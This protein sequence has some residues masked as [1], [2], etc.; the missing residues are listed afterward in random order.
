MRRRRFIETVAGVGVGALAASRAAY[1]ADAEVQLTLQDSTP[2]ISPH[3]YGHFIEHLGGVID[4]GVWVGRDSRVPNIEGIRKQFLDDMKRIATPNL[5]W[6]GG[7]FADAYH[8]RDGIGPLAHRP[9]R[10][11]FWQSRMPEGSYATEPNGF[12]TH[13]FMRLC[14]LLGAEPYLAANVGSGTPREFHD[15]VSY[16]N[17]PPATESLADERAANGERDPFRVRYWGVGNES[18]GCGGDMTPVEYAT[19]YR[20][21]VTQ[22][23]VYVKPFLVATGPRGH[24]RDRDLAWTTGFFEAMKGH[25]SPVD[26]FSLHFYSDF[27]NTKMKVGTFGAPE[28]YAVL[29]EGL[30][31]ESVLLEHWAAM[32]KLDPE[33]RTRLLVDEWGVWYPPGEEITPRYILSQPLTLR[34]ALHTALTFDVFNRHAD[35][36]EMANVAQTVNCLHSLFLAHEDKYTRTPVY[37]VF[38]MYRGHMGARLVPMQIRAG[39]LAVAVPEGSARIAGLLG[40]ASIRGQRVLVTLTNPSLDAPITARIRLTGGSHVTEAR[41]TVLTHRDMHAANTFENPHAVAPSSLPVTIGG[42][43]ATVTLPRQAIAAVELQIV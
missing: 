22:F 43:A 30:R 26:G 12:G 11:N 17:A 36:V 32:G 1:A 10:Y 37:S 13:E 27:R 34:D 19:L 31:T 35:K 5:R 39:D 38:E 7:C 15:W 4:D 3:L 20:Q 18:W 16:C 33:H 8:W 9:R 41:G 28:W 42:D 24:A 25:R 6:P 14:R 21:F 23:P 40:S 2:V 29:L